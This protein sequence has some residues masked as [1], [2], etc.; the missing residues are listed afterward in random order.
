MYSRD[1]LKE[2]KRNFW[3]AF[4][5]YCTT[6]PQLASRKSQFMLYNTK[7]KG[8]ELKFDATRHGAYVILEIN[9][10]DPDRR[11]ELF[12]HAQ[13]CRLLFE[14]QLGNELVWELCYMRPE[15]KEVSRIYVQK[16]GL[17][18][19]RPTDWSLFHEFMA[20]NMLKMERAFRAFKETL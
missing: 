6:I 1:E 5:D 17:D 2:L 4:S 3:I 14:E 12:E 19:H 8:V 7:L 11:F 15:G 18:M 9:H 16:L 10:N 20:S 13:A